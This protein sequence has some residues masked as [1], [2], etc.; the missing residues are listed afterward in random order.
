MSGHQLPLVDGGFG[1]LRSARWRWSMIVCASI[2]V[3]PLLG[4]T[5]SE[6]AINIALNRLMLMGIVVAGPN[7][8]VNYP[9]L[10]DGC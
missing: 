3:P 10:R 6:E 4:P 2:D 7:G 8:E 9:K 1:G 5:A